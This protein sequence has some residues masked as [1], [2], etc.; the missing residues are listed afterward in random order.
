MCNSIRFNRTYEVTLLQKE[1][2]GCVQYDWIQHFNQRDYEG[3]WTCISL[4][5][6]DGRNETIVGFGGE[7]SYEDTPLLDQLPYMR[8]V[9]DSIPG[10]KE[11]IR[12]MA[13]YPGAE[14]KPHK[15]SGC[16]YTDGVYRIHVPVC[17]HPDVEFYLEGERIVMEEGSCWYLDFSKTHQ[18]INKSNQVRVHLVVDGIRDEDTD[19]WF[20]EN[21]YKEA[22]KP[23]YDEATKRAMIAQLEMMEGE[24]A[25]QLVLQ[26]KKELQDA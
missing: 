3:K 20:F 5:S 24:G 8:T 11:S 21:G 18:I 13:L 19:T 16:S 14:I 9:I 26:L 7:R 4:R 15:D 10:A 6:V 22:P 17:T 25:R 12:L 1:L 2:Q 23:D